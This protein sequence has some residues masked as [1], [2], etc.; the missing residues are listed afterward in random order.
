MLNQYRIFSYHHSIQSSLSYKKKNFKRFRTRKFDAIAQ[1]KFPNIISE[2][3]FVAKSYAALEKFGFTS[4]NCI[5][6]VTVCRDEITRTFVESIDALWNHSFNISSL[7][8]MPVCGKTGFTAALTHAPSNEDGTPRYVFYCAPHIAISPAGEVGTLLRNVNDT[9]CSSACGALISL[10]NEMENN[11]VDVSLN[12]LDVEQS[13][14][15]QKVINK[16]KYGEI[17]S[18]IRLTKLTQEIILDEVMRTIKEVVPDKCEYAV[19]SGVQIHQTG[20][21]HFFDPGAMFLCK[22]GEVIDLWETYQEVDA[23]LYVSQIMEKRHS[24]LSIAVAHGRLVQIEKYLDPLLVNTVDIHGRTLCQIAASEG[25]LDIVKYLVSIG[26]DLN[27]K[28]ENDHSPLTESIV[29]GHDDISEFLL[30]KGAYTDP[31]VLKYLLLEA[32]SQG[33]V[34]LVRR[35]SKYSPDTIFLKDYNDRTSLHMAKNTEV[36]Q[37]LLDSGADTEATDSFGTRARDRETVKE[38]IQK[39]K[40]N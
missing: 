23:K 16:L 28:D 32:S 20:Q 22:G 4:G 12:P 27:T 17:P 25:K 19:L 26:A 21:I 5:P 36:A 30:S 10:K 14:L 11:T 38:T 6:L 29:Q 8:G 35:I 37:I 2:E 3:M 24:A 39:N 7:A 31:Q 34:E 13:I 18:L 9:Q 15:R 40:K 1:V 33:D